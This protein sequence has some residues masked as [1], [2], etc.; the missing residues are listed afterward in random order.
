M[1]FL[2]KLLG[3][4]FFFSFIVPGGFF[5]PSVQAQTNDLM[6]VEYVDWN[7]GDGF[8]VEIFNP[9]AS[10]VSLS[11][12]NL[13]IYNNGSTTASSST[14]LS[15][16]LAPCGTIRVGNFTDCP[17]GLNYNI[18][19]V[20]GDDAIALTRHSNNAFVDMVGLVGGGSP[21]KVNNVSNAL[22]WNRLTRNSANTTRYTSTS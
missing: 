10:P 6:I 19:G 21:S 11:N 22:K 7:P 1:K 4:I 14:Q 8:A 13:N 18:A 17:L 2:P 20:N 3:C 9:T 16:N 5:T 12:Y 15:G